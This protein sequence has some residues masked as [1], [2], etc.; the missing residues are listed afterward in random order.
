MKPWR[1]NL[2]LSQPVRGVRL[3]AARSAREEQDRLLREREES[4]FERGRQAGER[5]LSE[6]LLQQRHD[7]LELQQGVLNS[8]PQCV[9][10]LLRETEGLLIELALEAARKWM[11]GQPIDVPAIEAC[12]REALAMMEEGAE[13]N[14]LLNAEDMALLEKHRSPLLLS[15]AG[16]VRTRLSASSEVTSGGCIVQTRFGTV[17][18]RREIKVA[19][20]QNALH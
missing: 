6:Q 18:A 19:L 7:L 11:A 5:A 9:P 17:D 2:R 3:L 16:P 15:D 10:R 12:V 20:L 13:F 4:A 8:L 1:E 14:V